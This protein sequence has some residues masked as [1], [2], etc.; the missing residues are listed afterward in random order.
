MITIV[1]LVYIM[2][3]NYADMPKLQTFKTLDEC[4][5]ALIKKVK[6]DKNPEKAENKYGCLVYTGPATDEKPTEKA[7]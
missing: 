7:S 1:Y 5:V 2:G 6:A 4:K 3:T